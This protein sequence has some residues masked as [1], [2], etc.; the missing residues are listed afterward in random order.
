MLEWIVYI[1][2]GEVNVVRA[3]SGI[4]HLDRFEI[5]NHGDDID[6]ARTAAYRLASRAGLP[7]AS[8]TDEPEN[9]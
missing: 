4:R 1:I 8:M 3:E 6:A 2:S 7:T 5:S 9:G